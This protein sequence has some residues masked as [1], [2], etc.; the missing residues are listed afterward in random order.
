MASNETVLVVNSVSKLYYLQYVS[1][2]I[3]KLLNKHF[4]LVQ[5]YFKPSEKQIT[6]QKKCQLKFSLNIVLK[7]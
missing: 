6:G 4:Q 7:I 2:G 1:M 5:F 3:S